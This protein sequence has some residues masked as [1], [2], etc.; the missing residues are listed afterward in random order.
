MTI[1]PEANPPGGARTRTLQRT[2]SPVQFALFGFGSIVGTAWVV[3]LGGWL[4]RAGPGGTLL[5]I[6]L[7]GASMA[8]IAAMYAELGSRFPQTGGEVTYIS[9]V[10]GKP[11]GFVVGWLLTLAYLSNLIFEGIALAWLLE[12][13][14]PPLA[15]PTL[16]VI[17]G[18]P[19]GLGGLL[20]A[21]ASGLVIAVLNY[22]G[23]HSF[24]RFQNVLTLGFLIVVLTAV[25]VELS[26]GSARNMQPLW[27]T[28]DGGSWFIGAIWVFGSVPMIFNGFQSVLHTI[29]ERSQST[30]K[31]TV[32]RLAAACVGAATLFYLLAVVG[33]TKAIPWMVLASSGLPAADALAGLPWAG[34]FRTAFLLALIASLLKAWNA[35]FM[36]TVRLLFAQS[37]EGMIPPIFNDVNPATG[38]PGK[39]VVVVAAVNVVGI[40]L[41][42]GFLDP[43]VNAMT[44]CIASIYVLICAATLVM[45]KRQP[46]HSGFQAWG[47]Y[48]LGIFAIVA[49]SGMVAFA[50]LQPAPTTQADVLKW[51]LFPAWAILGAGLYRR[52]NRKSPRIVP[53]GGGAEVGS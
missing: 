26:F 11:A 40:F 49:A 8:L 37:R 10:F 44:V 18:Q 50:L 27:R 2:I 35:V 13:L 41:G 42:K 24:V 46:D 25:A 5:G 3:L 22:R 39:A 43:I 6:A 12:M 45:R 38:A 19:I 16:Y 30:S 34:A 7:G 14:W 33:A 47:G 23:A 31:E 20:L 4:M 28:G 1:V 9:A 36:T 15:G 53:A 48:P 51:V 32:V 17:F 52:Q 29:E 21:V